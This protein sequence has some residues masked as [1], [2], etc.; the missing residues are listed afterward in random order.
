MKEFF[1]YALLGLLVQGS[2]GFL[3]PRSEQQAKYR[4]PSNKNS[5]VPHSYI[6]S[7]HDNH[8]I[9]DHYANIGVNISDVASDFKYLAPLNIYYFQLEAQNLTLIH[10]LIRRDP[11]IK[12][13]GHD[14]YGKT[15]IDPIHHHP[16][17]PDNDEPSHDQPVDTTI[18]KRWDDMFFNA[19]WHL[20]M[21][22]SWNEIR[23]RGSTVYP[24]ADYRIPWLED[25]G[26][27]VNIYIFDS[28]IRLGLSAFGT[29]EGKM[30]NLHSL[31]EEDKAPYC[32]NET[33]R[34]TEGH[35]TKVAAVAAGYNNGFLSPAWRAN[36]LSVKVRSITDV[37]SEHKKYWESPPDGWRGSVINVSMGFPDH[38]ADPDFQRAWEAARAAGIPIA[39]A[40]GNSGEN[41]LHVPAR[42]K[43]TYS[44]G[45]V[46]S[47]YERWEASNYHRKLNCFAPGV[48]VPTVDHIT[49]KPTTGDGTSVASPLVAGVMAMMVG[50]EGAWNI[51]DGKNIYDRLDANLVP[52][53]KMDE[54]MTKAGVDPNLVNTGFFNPDKDFS[55]HPYAGIPWKEP[56]QIGPGPSINKRQG[57][58]YDNQ[59]GDYWDKDYYDG[60][61]HTIEFAGA[62]PTIDSPVPE[63]D[64]DKGY[65]DS[66]EDTCDCKPR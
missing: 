6:V 12:R 32:D 21:I 65:F 18:G 10:E 47:R 11:G 31:K 23:L 15:E 34:D 59:R 20:A 43:S 45:A 55:R 38:A 30:W 25:G 2:H 5:I 37:I 13:V 1:R 60:P 63:G 4:M 8:T 9:E 29:Q 3:A 54:N 64:L 35:G 40:A 49:G 39:A 16:D 61:Q 48:R 62:Q 26:K 44:V 22:G 41:W 46:D 58:P 17:G 24:H 14:Y 56:L 19:Q 53:V 28:G 36:L 33:M 52:L 42:W 7:L 27:G 50:Y 51:P 66:E 57:N